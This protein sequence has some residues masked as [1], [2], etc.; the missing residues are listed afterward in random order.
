MLLAFIVFR[1]RGDGSAPGAKPAASAGKQAKEG[2]SRRG[3]KTPAAGPSAPETAASAAVTEVE[4]SDGGPGRV[5]FFSPWGGSGMDQLGRERPQEGNP[6]GPMSLAQDGK[7]RLYVLDQ[8]N[9]RVVRHGPDGKPEATIELKLEGAQDLSVGTDGSMAVLDRLSSKAVALYD[10]NGAL[11][12]QLP[13]QGELV[14][15]TGLVTGV[16]VDGKDVYVEREHGPLVRIGDTDGSLASPRTEIPG[17]PSRD[18]KLFLNA[19]IIDAP[20]GRSYV[21]AIDRA[22]NQHRFTRELR[23]KGHITSIQL[24]DSDKRGTIYFAAEVGDEQEPPAIVLTCLEPQRG[25]PTG[26]AVLPANTLPEETFRDLTV[27]DD[28]GVVLAL[29]SDQGVTYTRYDCR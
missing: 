12:T 26:T 11:R 8:V 22:T 10:E 4:R 9:H 29:R 23:L 14:E 28:G 16:F 25:A 24:L 27:L 1:G 21:S 20:A 2:R 13:L 7:G 6:E 3:P 15:E 18:G 19:G 5:V 17:R